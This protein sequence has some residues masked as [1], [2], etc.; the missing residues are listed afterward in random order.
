METAPVIAF[1]IFTK[2][3]FIAAITDLPW[4][5]RQSK[6][7]GFDQCAHSEDHD[8]IHRMNTQQKLSIPL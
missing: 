5:G 1:V 4:A 8:L 3:S 6:D 2:N 7:C